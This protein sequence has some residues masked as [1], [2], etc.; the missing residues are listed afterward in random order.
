MPY[1]IRFTTY[2]LR[3]LKKTP[4]NL[5][6]LLIK[7]L[8][9]IKQAPYQVS[10]LSGNFS[11]LRSWHVY[12]RGVPYRIVYEVQENGKEILVHVLAK[13]ADVYKLLERLYK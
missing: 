5:Q 10:Q 11:F 6:P 4:I 8:E 2:A 3:L 7:E 9:V 12:L 13:R 1:L